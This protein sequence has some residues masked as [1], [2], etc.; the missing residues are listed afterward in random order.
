MT[1]TKFWV[2]VFVVWSVGVYRGAAENIRHQQ[3]VELIRSSECA[4]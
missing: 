3:L 4:P 1:D 2:L